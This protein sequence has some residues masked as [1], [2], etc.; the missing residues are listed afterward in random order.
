MNRR[1]K[2]LTGLARA[3]L[4][5]L[6]IGALNNPVALK[7][8]GKV[9]YVDHFDTN[10][11]REKYRKDPNVDVAAIV[12]VDAIWGVQTLA[13]CIGENRKVDYV[14]A[15]HVI[16]HVPDL[17]TWLEEISAIL[18]AT[19][20]VRLAVPD[21]RFTFDYFR[22][23]TRFCELVASWMVRARRPQPLQIADHM[24]NVTQID[25][26]A[27][28]RQRADP[29]HRRALFDFP[30]VP[31]VINDSL[32]NG[33]YHD[34]H[35]WIFTPASFAAL[36]QDIL[37]AG[38]TDLGCA[39]FHDTAPGTL[40]FIVAMKRMADP[41]DAARS[42]I[43][44][45]EAARDLPPVPSPS[46]PP[47]SDP[48]AYVD[49]LMGVVPALQETLGGLRQLLRSQNEVIEQQAERESLRAQLDL[50]RRSTSW[51]ITAP[52]RA[53]VD[54]VRHRRGASAATR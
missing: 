44:M 31:A 9:I 11:L 21:R 39:F 5:G 45:Q 7:S 47:P 26:T 15:S 17:I 30:G 51:R 38:L 28:W 23:E 3:D 22:N 36:M 18:T 40:E 52:V 8:E 48:P 34:V 41:D 1:E 54:A 29:A 10:A 20:E 24:L 49:E 42:W 14:V 16:E 32:T 33:T 37:R 46:D 35:C 25:L 50:I 4:L 6:E 2:L 53:A 43:T 27:A 13:Q 19:G 12:D